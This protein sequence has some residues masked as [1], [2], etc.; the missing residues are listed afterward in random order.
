MFE[1][2]KKNETED[3]TNN[4]LFNDRERLTVSEV[5]ALKELARWQMSGKMAGK[6]I[7]AI[8]LMLG[9][10]ATFFI[11]AVEFFDRHPIGK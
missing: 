11:T 3:F 5:K 8:V 10:L 4:E 9:G 1:R 2:F 6:I 7:V